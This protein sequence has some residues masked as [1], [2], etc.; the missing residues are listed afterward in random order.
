MTGHT[1]CPLEA[2]GG[3]GVGLGPGQHDCASC[4][5]RSQA[6]PGRTAA[7]A[8]GTPT[9]QPSGEEP[10]MRVG[11][12]G[13]RSS[14]YREAGACHGA[15]SPRPLIRLPTG[16]TVTVP[17]CAAGRSSVRGAAR[18]LAT[19]GQAKEG[20]DDGKDLCC[21]CGEHFGGTG[22]SDKS[23]I[24]K[25]VRKSLPSKGVEEG[26]AWG[27]GRLSLGPAYWTIGSRE[28][29]APGGWGGRPGEMGGRQG[30]GGRAQHHSWVSG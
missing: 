2:P 23:G 22:W 13:F 12:P 20:A 8:R 16:R 18:V 4:G 11:S 26:L 30:E 21:L 15:K 27:W 14:P 3:C 17:C 10:G 24:R 6:L 1:V 19:A 25:P 29:G 28:E 9:L 7:G 5:S